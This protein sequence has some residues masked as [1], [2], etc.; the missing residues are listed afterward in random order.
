MNYHQGD[1]VEN[2][3]DHS[4]SG[5]GFNHNCYQIGDDDGPT[6]HGEQQLTNQR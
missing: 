5:C 4:V 1:R 2:Q 6:Y 3:R